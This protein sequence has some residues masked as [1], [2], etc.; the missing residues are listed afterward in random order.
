MYLDFWKYTIVLFRSSIHNCGAWYL[1]PALAWFTGNTRTSAMFTCGGREAAQTISS[2]I[3][4]A[5]TTRISHEV[6]QKLSY[7]GLKTYKGR[8]L[9]R[10][11]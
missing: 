4:C 5:V 7:S 9:R 8:V 11:S 2:A 6:E 10:P 3:S 1:I